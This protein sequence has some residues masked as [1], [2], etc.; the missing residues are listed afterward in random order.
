MIFYVLK[1]QHAK[2]LLLACMIAFSIS[3]MQAQNSGSRLTNQ[4]RNFTLEE[5]I[6]SVEKSTGYSF[7]YGEEVKLNQRI[8]FEA[9]DLSLQ[10]VLN[11]AFAK[12]PIGYKITGKHILLFK[13][14][15]KP[16]GRKCTISGYITD[17]TSRETLIGANIYENSHQQGT[18]TNPYGF[19][20]IT[21]PEGEISLKFSYIG[22][23][24]QDCFIHLR[25]DTVI[26]VS[27]NNNNILHEVTIMSDKTETGLYA[28]QMGT[29]D[30]PLQ[31]IK[32][33]PTILGEA[34]VIKSIQLLP[35]VQTGMDGSAG[36]YVR[37]G[38]PD[39]NLILLDGVPM[40]N[41]EHLFGFFSVFTPEAVKKV[42]LF[43]SS[44]PARFGGRLSSVLD[45]R[46]ND[47]DM[48]RYH[49]SFS[50]GLLSTKINLE[51][52]IVKGKTSFN[53]SA[54]RSYADLLIAPFLNKGDKFGYYF[55]DVNAKINHKFSDKSRLFLS[56]YNGR[57]V[58][59]YDFDSSEKYVSNS[60]EQ[61]SNGV[62][63]ETRSKDKVNF[64]WGSTIVS[65]RWNYIF[66]NKLFSNTT[67]AYNDYHFKLNMQ[68]LEKE[69]RDNKYS[70]YNY[71]AKYNSGI[72]DWTYNIDFDYD[73]V[74]THHVKFGAGYLFHNFCPEVI[75]SKIHQ[76]DDEQLNDTTYHGASNSN[77][78]A[79]EVSVYGEDN[80]NLTDRFRI[81]AGAHIS[82]F[83]VQNQS[84]F[85]I[86]PRFSFRYQLAED[87]AMKGSYTK[88]NQYI[89]LLSNSNISLPT[90]L[91]VPTTKKI[92]PMISHQYSVGGYY[93]GL[94]DWE[95]SVEGYY[96]AMTNV[97]EYKDGASFSGS[98]SGWENKVEMGKGRSFGLEF[99]AQKVVGK[100]TGWIGYTLAKSDRQFQKGGIN[101]GIRFPYK[102][103]RRHNVN[104]TLNQKLTKKV[105]MFA[106]W[107]FSTGNV[108]TI[109]EEK[110]SA[111]RPADVG[112]AQWQ[113]WN[114]QDSNS[115][116]GTSFVYTDKYISSRN[117]YRLP[118]SQCLNIG[119]NF[120][121]KTKHGMRT[122]NFSIYN[123]YNAMNPSYIY[124]STKEISDGKIVYSRPIIK[125]VTILPCIPSFTYTYKF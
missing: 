106:S 82:C 81:N 63:V 79:H 95:F 65:G 1:S 115:F 37:G 24:S 22:Y 122:W 40:Y 116:H 108:A 32:N 7:I 76:Q 100:T 101:D 35:G 73:P 107:S 9:N 10:D 84:Y 18:T 54:R 28:T 42:S 59:H 62:S 91:W 47:G 55:Y 2:R 27:L 92:K 57:D 103:D 67:I 111:I 20:S 89:H 61:S 48:E 69:K 105:E 87:F 25:K 26:N 72:K 70:E 75:T 60:Q 52:P 5:F 88:M 49:G 14:K 120:N 109:A 41:V 3:L 98:S 53:I 80:F 121:K 23:K 38:G 90:D 34:D 50:I 125:K 83:N 4:F 102:Y 124:M 21:L 51:G 12:E 123:V 74:P 99:L 33:T 29:I 96:K 66:S 97:L 77:I 39:Q 93:T 45:V 15:I 86:Q 110:T 118:N 71:Q 78:Y 16:V 68:S 46:T 117:N 36:M 13:K 112:Y 94:K 113:W 31:H 19:F 104:I 11:R 30:V 64:N 44:F 17:G 114:M 58:Y 8:S 85:S 43:K 56:T 119:I 6:K